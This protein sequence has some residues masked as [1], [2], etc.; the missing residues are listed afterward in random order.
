MY[1]PHWKM[2]NVI[3]GHG[4][5]MLESRWRHPRFRKTAINLMSLKRV[6]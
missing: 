3:I 4:S 6:P 5:R 1:T 2:R